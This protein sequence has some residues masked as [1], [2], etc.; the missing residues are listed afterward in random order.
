MT[1][2]VLTVP[3]GEERL[4]EV[5]KLTNKNL[6]ES[7]ELIFLKMLIGNKGLFGVYYFNASCSNALLLPDSIFS[8][9]Y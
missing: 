7:M 5:G 2:P 1:A 4:Q 9:M 3:I 6:W 8:Y